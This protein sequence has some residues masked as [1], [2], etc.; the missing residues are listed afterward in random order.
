MDDVVDP[1]PQCGAGGDHLQRFDQPGLLPR[2]ELSELF[3]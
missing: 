2:F 1:F 3:T